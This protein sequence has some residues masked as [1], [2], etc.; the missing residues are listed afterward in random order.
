MTRS[1][2][3]LSSC[4]GDAPGYIRESLGR[5]RTIGS[6]TNSD[7]YR[8]LGTSQA[9]DLYAMVAQ[10]DADL[11]TSLLDQK[12]KAIETSF[13]LDC[14]GESLPLN[15]DL[16]NVNPLSRHVGGAVL[17][18]LSELAPSL[19][20]APN[21]MSARAVATALSAHQRRSIQRIEGTAMLPVVSDL[22]YDRI[23][24][25]RAN[26]S[27]LRPL[28]VFDSD[29]FG[30]MATAIGLTP[31]MSILEVGCGTGRFSALIADRG[32]HLTALD[33]SLN[34]LTVARGDRAGRIEYVQG[35]AN[36]A[37]PGKQFDVV[38]FFFSLQYMRLDAK[39]WSRV[40]TALKP[41]GAIAIATFPH[42]HFVETEHA[43][44]FPAIPRI[45]M[46]R[47]P[48]L[49]ALCAHL[50]N[51]G[52]CDVEIREVVKHEVTKCSDLI[53][54]T[55]ARYLSTF[56]LLS[57][58]EFERGLGAMRAAYAGATTITRALR[59]AVVSARS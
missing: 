11:E 26:Y 8:E 3:G 56:H 21:G 46:A 24:D 34:M 1:F 55:Q 54:R 4:S 7:L 44:F 14:A 53:A 2:V 50:R 37:L 32:A 36:V 43:R 5:L 12:L 28:S 42:R 16:L 45:D 22:D 49:P 9:D 47:F 40:R 58:D 13:S 59:A 35:D 17:L 15:V 31:D 48:S 6:V 51:N 20:L 41:N 38:V 52:F 29:I 27:N 23:G 10:L 19:Q 33:K 39:F 25:A 30:E 57:D 18:A